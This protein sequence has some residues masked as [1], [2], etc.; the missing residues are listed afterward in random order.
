MDWKK[1]R[2]FVL[3][4][5]FLLAKNRL[6]L[7]FYAHVEKAF[8]GDV[9]TCLIHFF[10]FCLAK[11]VIHTFIFSPAENWFEKLV[12]QTH[13]WRLLMILSLH[14]VSAS[15]NLSSVSDTARHLM[16]LTMIILRKKWN[17][18]CWDILPLRFRMLSI[19]SMGC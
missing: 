17:L 15:E 18:W 4:R 2:N 16:R 13:F 12:S 1:K 3:E 5:N 7:W 6:N 14:K 9:T 19:A 10:H 11:I 8:F